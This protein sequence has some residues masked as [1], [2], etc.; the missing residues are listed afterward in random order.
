MKR[1]E[2]IDETARDMGRAALFA[3]GNLVGAIVDTLRDADVPAPLIHGILD[4]IDDANRAVL[5]GSAQE[6]Y[7]SL[8]A[9]IRRDIPGND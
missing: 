8:V 4:H 2:F 6:A 1:E 3:W 9:A 5:K 7:L